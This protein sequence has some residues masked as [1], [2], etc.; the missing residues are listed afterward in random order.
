MK[1]RKFKLYFSTAEPA[2]ANAFAEGIN[3]LEEVKLFDMH[4]YVEEI[5]LLKEPI[6]FQE[7]LL[8][9]SRQ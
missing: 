3:Q 7:S 6:L 1:S 9:R 2:I 5:R 8:K 4:F